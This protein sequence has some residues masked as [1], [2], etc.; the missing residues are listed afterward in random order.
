MTNAEIFN[1]KLILLRRK[2]NKEKFL[3][4]N[5]LHKIAAEEIVFRTSLIKEEFPDILELGYRDN[6]LHDFLAKKIR[7]K[8]YQISEKFE[9]M[10]IFKNFH[11]KKFDLIVSNLTFHYLNNLPFIMLALKKLLKANGAIIFSLFGNDTL[12]NVK[13]MIAQIEMNLISKAYQRI[14]PMITSKDLTEILSA[15]KFQEII[16]DCQR[17]QIEYQSFHKLADD[18]RAMS[19]TSPLIGNSL[20]NKEVYNEITRKFTENRIVNFDL[21]YV[22]ALN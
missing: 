17:Q 1:H 22:T 8:N 21:I 9:D 10:E 5:F 16:V 15:V 7:F 3:T 13:Q 19:E 4:A 18:L 6:L 20:I 14:I 11:E 12:L 2:K